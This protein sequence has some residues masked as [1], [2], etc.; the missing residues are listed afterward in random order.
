MKCEPRAQV[1]CAA[2]DRIGGPIRM[3]VR[4][5]ESLLEIGAGGVQL[6]DTIRLMES[7]PWTRAAIRQND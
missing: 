2:G 4:L 7:P 1:R 6:P 5:P 3:A